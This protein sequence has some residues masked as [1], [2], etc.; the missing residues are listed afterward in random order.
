MKPRKNLLPLL[1]VLLV[2]AIPSQAQTKLFKAVAED[3]SQETKPI[4]QDGNLVGYLAFTQLE[5]Q[6]P[7]P[8]TTV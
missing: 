7:T 6:A 3:M 5:R 8:S 2:G 4:V 1:C